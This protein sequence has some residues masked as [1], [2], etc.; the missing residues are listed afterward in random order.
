[1]LNVA[2]E[3]NMKLGGINHRLAGDALG[4]LTKE[5]TIL[6]GIDVSH[7]GPSSVPGTLSITGVVA[8]I[9]RDFVQ[10]PVSLRLQ[11]SKQEVSVQPTGVF[12]SGSLIAWYI[13]LFTFHRAL[14]N[15]WMRLSSSGRCSAGTRMSFQNT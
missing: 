13:P 1:L 8:S 15:F 10:F 3:V 9:D 5:R 2:L 11:K 6:V 12:H 7:P 14:P 4:W